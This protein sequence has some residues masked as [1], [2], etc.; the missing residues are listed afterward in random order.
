[1]KPLALCFAV[2]S[3]CCHCY[4]A[5]DRNGMILAIQN[6][7][8]QGDL[9]AAAQQI[10]AALAESPHDGG[11]LN[12][13]GIVHARTG[14][15]AEAENDFA[16]AIKFAPQLFGAYL[17][18]GRLYLSGVDARP[19]LLPKAIQIYEQALK[20]Q[21]DSPE[22]HYQLAL[23]LEWEGKFSQSLGHLQRLPLAEQSKAHVLSL[24]CADAAALKQAAVAQATTQQL[25]TSPDLTEDDVLS[26]LPVLESK[27][28]DQLIQRL[29]QALQKRG[30][31]SS[32]SLVHLAAA[33]ERSNQYAEAR[34]AL[35]T[36]A[37]SQPNDPKPL[38]DLARVAYKQKDLQGSLGYLAHARDLAP[39]NG[40]IHFA[41][42]LIALQM[43][44][45]MEAQNSLKKAVEIDPQNPDFNYGMGVAGL[46]NRDVTMSVPYFRKLL[47]LRNDPRGHYGLGLAFYYSGSY[48]QAREEMLKIADLPAFAGGAH[49]ILGRV[50][51]ANDDAALAQTEFTRA[52]QI[53]PD[54]VEAR[55]ELAALLIRSRH[56]E[57]AEQELTKALR[58][59]PENVFVNRKLLQL[60]Q[61]E[62]SPRAAEQEQKLKTC[63]EKQTEQEQLLYRKIE[64]HPF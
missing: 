39:A 60:Y 32:N 61:L 52:L 11:L 58:L 42:G 6:L 37:Q 14:H 15:E 50:A 59:A 10:S 41:F 47:D 35:E 36:L 4:A 40:G 30:L 20:L 27:Q 31:A 48:E 51:N 55:G 57:E 44:L 54:N 2:I 8:S 3:L 45:P 24:R 33:C 53:A 7:I 5:P 56:Y 46:Y 43:H 25:A 29:V 34:A 22:C 49:L 21:P 13:Q 17:N 62:K 38:V 19:D 26:I 1:M 64:V 18:L 16:E 28:E 23:L 63:E 9:A 12:L